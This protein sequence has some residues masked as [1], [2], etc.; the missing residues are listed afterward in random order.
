LR[1]KTVKMSTMKYS[2]STI[3]LGTLMCVSGTILYSCGGDGKDG[4]EMTAAD[5]AAAE[6][7]KSKAQKVFYA[8]PSPIEMSNIIKKC[9]ANYNKDILNGI[10][11]VSRYS[12]NT[13]KAINLGIYGADLSYTSIFDQTQ[14]SMFYMGNC[15]KLADGLGVTGA[16]TPEMISRIEASSNNK[17]S[18]LQIISDSYL[19]TDAYLKENDRANV[20]GLVIAGGWMEGL[21]ISAQIAK[22][23][24]KNEV[25]RKSIAEQKLSL[26]NLIGLLESYPADE[27]VT[28]VLNDLKSI[29]AIYDNVS[30][31]STA[32]AGE[33]KSAEGTP[34]VGKEGEIKASEEQ[35]AAI[36][37]KID[38]VR[39]KWTK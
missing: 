31:T 25:I 30:S 28:E 12:T 10:Q 3:A 2:F 27:G 32:S 16:F 21:Y 15:K 34:T 38:E 35:V 19:A 11:N 20:S 39:N 29:N 6:V 23:N 8:I 5:S 9:G 7:S 26:A 37:A 18:L 17:D 13:A 14:E 4:T 22:A 1:I 33:T 36:T 24:P